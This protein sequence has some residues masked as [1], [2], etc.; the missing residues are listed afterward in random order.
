MSGT[1]GKKIIVFIASSLDGF[2]ARKDGDVS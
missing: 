2:I 1:M